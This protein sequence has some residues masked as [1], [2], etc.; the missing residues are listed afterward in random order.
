MVIESSVIGLK[1]ALVNSGG[2]YRL[3]RYFYRGNGVPAFCKWFLNRDIIVG[4]VRFCPN[5]LYIAPKID[6]RVF[7]TLI[8]QI[9]L[10][11]VRD[12]SFRD[13]AYIDGGFWVS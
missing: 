13:S 5:G 6:D 11:S 1:I 9:L 3:I 4:S 10:H 2:N 7:Y 8:L 12:I